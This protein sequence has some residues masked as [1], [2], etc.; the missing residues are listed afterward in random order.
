VNASR[1]TFLLGVLATACGRPRHAATPTAAPS[2]P[3]A[4]TATAPSAVP[5]ATASVAAPT[6]ANGAAAF[7]ASGPATSQAVALTFHGSGDPVLARRLLAVAKSESLLLTLFAVGAWLDAQPWVARAFLDAG[8]ELANHTRTHPALGRLGAA[9][10]DAEVT[11]GR[12]ALR[13][14]AGSGGLWFRP[15]GIAVP[16]PLILRAAARAGY[17]TVV[18]YDVD[19]RDYQD[20]GAAAVASRVVAALHPGAIVSLHTGHAGTVAAL[21]RIAAALRSRGLRPVTTRELL[22]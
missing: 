7:V 8:H 13:R 2:T 15:S 5:P 6:P 19:P 1:R 17:P 14:H 18:G 11:G 21:P 22:G 9:A 16:T 10:V 20:P 12:D 3:A 4:T